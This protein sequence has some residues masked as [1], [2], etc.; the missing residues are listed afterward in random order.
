MFLSCLLGVISLACLPS[1][2]LPQHTLGQAM[3]MLAILYH[4]EVIAYISSICDITTLCRWHA[5]LSTHVAYTDFVYP[6]FNAVNISTWLSGDCSGRMCAR[7]Q[8]HALCPLCCCW[9]GRCPVLPC[10]VQPCP[11]SPP[12]LQL[13]PWWPVLPL[14]HLFLLRLGHI[15]DS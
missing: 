5:T 3:V 1:L 15:S 13:W 12:T 7:S 2:Q 14:Y 6:A 9:L 8:Q 11:W 10:L 4:G